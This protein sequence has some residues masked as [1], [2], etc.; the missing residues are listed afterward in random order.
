M[1]IAVWYILSQPDTTYLDLRPEHYDRTRNH[2]RALRNAIQ[3]LN[4]LGYR[5]TL[6]AA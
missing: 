3:R 6:E 5:V 4:A 1:L 2:D